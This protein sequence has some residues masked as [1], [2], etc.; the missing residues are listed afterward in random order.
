MF[1][2]IA[3]RLYGSD[4]ALVCARGRSKKGKFATKENASCLILPSQVK[5]MPYYQP[6]IYGPHLPPATPITSHSDA[7]SCLGLQSAIPAGK[8]SRC[9]R[10]LGLIEG[11]LSC[12]GVGAVSQR[13]R[14]HV[15]Q[16]VTWERQTYRVF[17]SDT[18]PDT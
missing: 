6:A 10:N 18:L 15:G 17:D 2:D 7:E 9:S 12:P 13:T 1:R 8:R 3:D 5:P 11:N 4:L 14:I 16:N